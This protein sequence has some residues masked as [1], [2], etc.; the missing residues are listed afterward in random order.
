MRPERLPGLPLLAIN[1]AGE[2]IAAT[3]DVAVGLAALPFDILSSILGDD[4][5][6]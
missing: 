3:V 5:D 4:D 1:T 2:V 6:D